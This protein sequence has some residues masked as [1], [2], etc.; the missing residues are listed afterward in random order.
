[1]W[2]GIKSKERMVGCGSGWMMTK[3]GAVSSRRRMD[4]LAAMVSWVGGG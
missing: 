1:M 2:S 3:G 4:A